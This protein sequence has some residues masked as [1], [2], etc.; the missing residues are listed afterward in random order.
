[1][2]RP[3][4]RVAFVFCLSLGLPAC[5]QEKL[6]PISS[7]AAE[8]PAYAAEY[9]KRLETTHKRFQIER[10]FTKDFDAEFKRF[11]EELQDPDWEQVARVYMLAEQ[12][13]KSS[14]YAEVRQKNADVAQFFVDEKKDISRKISG[15]VHYQAEQ[16]KCDA[17]FYATIDRGLENGVK[18]RFEKREDSGSQAAQYIALHESE[19]GK[20]APILRGHARSLSAAAQLVYVDLAV[21]HRELSAMVEEVSAVKKTIDRRLQELQAPVDE[22][23]D[24]VEGK[25]R[26]QER[27]AL[28]QAKQ[29]VD[30][31]VNAVKKTVETS[32]QDVVAA[33]ESFETALDHLRAELKKRRSSG[34]P[35]GTP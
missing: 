29:E 25:A 27:E 17:K 2:T 7:P 28:T 33:R 19:L 32:E 31:A 24:T 1:M 20:N 4:N 13:G 16:E 3:M 11:P 6:G 18:E 15:G 30:A 5:S 9:P 26:A 22:K 12:D 10:S 8:H 21:R 14:H 35:S 34:K 23:P